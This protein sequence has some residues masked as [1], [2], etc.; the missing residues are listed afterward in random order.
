[1]HTN[2]YMR[3][4]SHII[5]GKTKSKYHKLSFSS[6]KLFDIRCFFSFQRTV[7]LNVIGAK[8][9]PTQLQISTVALRVSWEG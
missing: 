9:T 2:T 4:F 7:M 3:M 8:P 5:F 1:M 6:A